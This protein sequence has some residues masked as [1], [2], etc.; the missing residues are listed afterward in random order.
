MKR[1]SIGH[2]FL[3]LCLVLTAVPEAS[4]TNLLKKIRGGD[5]EG[6]RAS[7]EAGASITG[8]KE[9][10]PVLIKRREPEG[11]VRTLHTAFA[12]GG[13]STASG[14]AIYG[15]GE[16]AQSLDCTGVLADAISHRLIENED[17][18]A[19]TREHVQS[20][21]EEH[22]LNWGGR[23]N[24][25]KVSRV[26][27]L[28]GVQVLIFAKVNYCEIASNVEPGEEEVDS[29][30]RDV[31][32]TVDAAGHA[33][34]ALGESKVGGV[35]GLGADLL[36]RQRNKRKAKIIA[37]VPKV[38]RLHAMVYA[39]DL[40]TGEKIA[41]TSGEV[42]RSSVHQM[43]PESVS[44]RLLMF[45]A[46]SEIA[47]DFVDRI[48]NRPDFDYVQMY[49]DPYVD[50][51]AGIRLVRLGDCKAAAEVFDRIA[52]QNAYRA[53]DETNARILHNHGVALL[54]AGRP[55]SA[56]WKF[57]A[58]FR[59]LEAPETLDMID[60]SYLIE[61]RNLDMIVEEDPVMRVLVGNTLASAGGAPPAAPSVSLDPAAS[62]GR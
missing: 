35:L 10:V 11:S 29:G 57:R 7:G 41:A 23:F 6:D 3:C 8:G 36:Q 12:I 15:Y 26:G 50:L 48:L 30:G 16:D 59:L 20:I 39:V 24:T 53:A 44:E 33:A 51:D 21:F 45:S 46:A 58:S 13:A 62:G 31:A 18:F 55:A 37:S 49:R 17:F 32:G 14:T 38:A 2:L 19:L 56:Q 60:L 1:C 43:N 28:L 42:N 27:E 4:G 47:A 9:A 61:E 22:N 54:C 34:H 40:S 5:S 52:A 25:A